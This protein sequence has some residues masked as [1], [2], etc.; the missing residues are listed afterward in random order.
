M[1]KI[2][3]CAPSKNHTGGISV[4]ADN[5]INFYKQRGSTKFKIKLIK[6]DRSIFINH[7]D[8]FL[9]R[10]F[11]GII[12]YVPFLFVVLSTVIFNPRC[13]IHITSSGSYGL[14]RD[15]LV[16]IISKFFLAKV[17]LNFHFGKLPELKKK[18][19]FEFF[20][21][22]SLIKLTDFT[23]VLDNYSY[24]S[25]K[26]LSP[27][28]FLVP[29]PI[30]NYAITFYNLNKLKKVK[31]NIKTICFAGHIL[32]SKGVYD[33][34]S[35]VS[36]IKNVKLKLFGYI[37]NQTIHKKIC[38]LEKKHKNSRWIELNGEVTQENLWIEMI[39]SDLFVFPSW[40]EAFP[41]VILE[42]MC[43]EL[44]IISTNVG[45]IPEMLNVSDSQNSCGLTVDPQKVKELELSIVNLMS[46][47]K[48]KVEF[49]KNAKK[50]L[51]SKYSLENVIDSL[52]KIWE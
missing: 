40:S 32:E 7:R 39:K 24:K 12:D 46:D 42:A 23:I 51:L 9:K 20:I 25:I 38:E 35:A 48:K 1:K 13:T 45:A 49:T 6:T 47:N 21:I 52:E 16:L 14:L 30:S 8:F 26:F 29:N 41:N 36:K 4:W 15:F 33:L 11:F 19:S 22:K 31:N 44:P 50:R 34:I 37:P 10:L 27:N 17:G 28:I 5:I 43:M 2:F 18:K 3:I